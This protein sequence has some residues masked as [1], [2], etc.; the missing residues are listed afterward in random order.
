MKKL[1]YFII[2]A[3]FILFL[4]CSHNNNGH[5]KKITV[6]IQ[7]QKYFVQQITGDEYDIQVMVPEGASPATYDPTP[8][9]MKHLSKSNIYFRIGYIGF[10]Q[11]WIEQLKKNYDAVNF[12]NTAK[13]VEV[14]KS[15]NN[16]ID[17][18]IWMSPK[19][20]KQILKNML[21]ALVKLDTSNK[22][23]YNKNYSQ[24]IHQI[25][26]LDKR[27]Q[28][29]FSKLSKKTFLIYHPSLTYFAKDYH[30]NQVALEKEGKDLT[31]DLV[32]KAI[33]TAKEY[34]INT[35]LV[36]KEFDK[37]S[38]KAIAQEIN[39]KVVRINPLAENWLENMDSIAY[40]LEEAIQP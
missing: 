38:A 16:K 10:E 33:H 6:S 39:G 14:I 34:D 4:G 8:Q 11:A 12:I 15:S 19:R 22:K 40:K 37:S 13:D 21:T 2:P 29:R 28:T 18:H 9:Q 36:Q 17:P 32:K 30:L 5:K 20:T 31:A 24:L 3:L 25:D 26:S 27:L 1:Y 35:I 23:Q 7:P